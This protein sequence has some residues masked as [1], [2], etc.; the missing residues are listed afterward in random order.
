MCCRFVSIGALLISLVTATRS[1]GTLYTLCYLGG[2]CCIVAVGTCCATRSD[3]NTC[4]GSD[5]NGMFYEMTNPSIQGTFKSYFAG[6]S[7]LYTAHCIAPSFDDTFTLRPAAS[8]ERF[9]DVNSTVVPLSPN[10]QV[11]YKLAW[12]GFFTCLI[13]LNGCCIVDTDRKVCLEADSVTM[14]YRI[15]DT[16]YGD[17]QSYFVSTDATNYFGFCQAAWPRPAANGT[18]RDTLTLEVIEE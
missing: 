14:F 8:G 5:S 17:L 1:N 9:D 4:L 3:Q 18:W 16:R 2:N 10:P 13:Q 11:V 7:A 6:T 15:E 12:N